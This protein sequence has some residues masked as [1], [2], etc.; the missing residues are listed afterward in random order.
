MIILMLSFI[1]IIVCVFVAYYRGAKVSFWFVISLFFG[2]LAIP[3][4]LFSKPVL[5]YDN[6]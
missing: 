4:V 1:S 2:P 6:Q 3:F 5:Q